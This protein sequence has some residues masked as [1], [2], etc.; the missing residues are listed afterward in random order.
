VTREFLRPEVIS[1]SSRGPVVDPLRC[2]RHVPQFQQRLQQ[3]E[4]QP[5]HI[6]GAPPGQRGSDQRYFARRFKAHFGLSATSYRSRFA[7]RAPQLADLPDTRPTALR[8]P[9]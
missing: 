6:H 7:G 8:T 3:V 2:A 4:V 9:T 5:G 1:S